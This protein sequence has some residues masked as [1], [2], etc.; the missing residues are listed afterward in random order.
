MILQDGKVHKGLYNNGQLTK[1]GKYGTEYANDKFYV[2]QFQNNKRH[3]KGK[4]YHRD[5]TV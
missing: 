2:G 3:G 4:L 1:I 5:G